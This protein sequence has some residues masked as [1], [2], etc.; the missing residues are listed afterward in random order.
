MYRGLSETIF[1]AKPVQSNF[2]SF[3]AKADLLRRGQGTADAGA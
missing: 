2:E 1:P 3:G